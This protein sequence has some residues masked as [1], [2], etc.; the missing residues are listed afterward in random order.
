MRERG[1]GAAVVVLLC[2]LVAAGCG[3]D[4]AAPAQPGTPA[5][6]PTEVPATGDGPGSAAPVADP[7][8]AVEMPGPLK[9]RLY[10]PDMLIFDQDPL[11]DSMVEQIKEL[12]EV[13]AVEVIGLGNVAIENQALTVAAVDGGT[14]R[15]FTPAGSA[16]TQGVW[17]RVAG[18][19]LAIDPKLGKKLEDRDGNLALGS[20]D[21]A[22]VLHI[23]AYAEQPEQIDMVVNTAWVEDIGRMAFGNGLLISTDADDPSTIRKDVQRIVGDTASV[24]D[25][26]IASRLGLDPTGVQTALL[27]GGSIADVV[28]TFSYGVLGGGRIAPDPAWVRA[29]IT[30]ETVPILGN[31]TCHRAIFPQL[32]AALQDV[33][34]RG[35]A[36]EIHPGE[37]AGCYYPRFIA[38]T[39]TLSNHSFGLALDLNVPGN[40]RGTVG[41]MDRGVVQIFKKWGFAW[42]G[43]WG[44]TDPMHFEMAQLVDPR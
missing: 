31:V 4:R 5:E 34:S 42:G 25:L 35:L 16:Q 1:T 13:A 12:R 17:D 37:Y 9:D 44:Y 32:K 29:N 30:T 23:G 18:G 19:E 38:G 6:T 8:H 14:F 15:R 20:G 39:T 27:T 21:D 11:S 41:E 7:D 33:V 22:P 2:A 36:D 24:Q 26:D 40:Q 3:G 43:D 10:R 28:G